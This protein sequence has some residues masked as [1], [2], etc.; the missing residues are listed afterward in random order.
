MT[1]KTLL[2]W[3][4]LTFDIKISHSNQLFSYI[5][6]LNDYFPERAQMPLPP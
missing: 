3:N 6:G 5:E 2:F 4:Q 1:K